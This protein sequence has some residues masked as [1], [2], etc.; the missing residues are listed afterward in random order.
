MLTN[1]IY[2]YIKPFLTSRMRHNVNFKAEFNS[3]NSEFSFSL[4][5]CH[6]K[7]KESSLPYYLPVAERRIVGI[8]YLTRI[9]A[10]CEKQTAWSG[11]TDAF[12]HKPESA[13]E[14]QVYKIL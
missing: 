4:T 3:L 8:I 1:Y 2:I 10:L 11:M 14:N 9:L 7:I 5:G 12:M 6:Y 13:L